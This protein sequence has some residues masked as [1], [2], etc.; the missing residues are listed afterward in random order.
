MSDHQTELRIQQKIHGDRG[1]VVVP[2]DQHFKHHATEWNDPHKNFQRIRTT[3]PK[4][5]ETPK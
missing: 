5:T 2:G 1:Y 3:K 4:Q